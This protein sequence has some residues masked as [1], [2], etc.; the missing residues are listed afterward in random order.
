MGKPAS[1]A[2]KKDATEHYAIAASDASFPKPR[3]WRNDVAPGER[4]LALQAERNPGIIEQRRWA[5]SSRFTTLRIDAEVA[6]TDSDDAID[7]RIDIIGSCRHS[8]R[9]R[10]GVI[11][12]VCK[13]AARR[14]FGRSRQPRVT[15]D[16]QSSSSLTRGY[17]LSPL[18]G[19]RTT[20]YSEA[21]QAVCIQWMARIERSPELW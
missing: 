15:L 8:N 13:S 20:R 18:R 5:T 19:S 16:S 10:L 4:W 1:L 11:P 21:M 17:S 2:I 12:K 7:R 3:S 6:T 14:R 9:L